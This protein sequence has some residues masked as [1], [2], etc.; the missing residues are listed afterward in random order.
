[1]RLDRETA[2]RGTLRCHSDVWTVYIANSAGG[3]RRALSLELAAAAG[4]TV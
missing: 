3:A 1:V 4:T 2:D